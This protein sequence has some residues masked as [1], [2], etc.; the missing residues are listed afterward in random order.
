LFGTALS[1]GIGAFAFLGAAVLAFGTIA[2]AWVAVRPVL[3]ISLLVL[4]LGALV[5]L[6][7]IGRS[8]KVAKAT[9][10]VPARA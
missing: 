8:R 5:W 7:K 9:A 2:V 10:A 3:G 1:A 6:L 4:A